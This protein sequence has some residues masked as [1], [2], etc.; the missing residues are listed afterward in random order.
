MLLYKNDLFGELNRFRE[1]MNRWF[2]NRSSQYNTG[3]GYPLTN[4]YTVEDG[5]RLV[6]LLPGV[7][8]AKLDIHFDKGHLTISGEKPSD[9]VKDE[10]YI[11]MEREYGKFSRTFYLGDDIN[12][13]S[14]KASYKDGVL[15]VE[16]QKVEQ[17]KPRKIE[18]K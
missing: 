18:V 13:D 4:I 3:Y 15:T 6:A 7:D 5:Y 11:R 14:I 8:S 1:E 9:E 17:A 10:N 16:L 2:N 12:P